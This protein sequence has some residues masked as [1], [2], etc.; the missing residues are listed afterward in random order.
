[1]NSRRKIVSKPVT[2]TLTVRFAA[3]FI[4]FLECGMWARADDDLPSPIEPS[5]AEA[6]DWAA[7]FNDAQI[8]CYNGSMNAC[9]SLWLSKRVLMDTFLWQYGRT[10]GGRVDLAALRS[11]GAFRLGGPDLHCTDIFLGR[12]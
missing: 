10:C 4:I 11:A 5:L 7:D 3:M 9:D 6:G 2:S 12:E 8:A 1:M